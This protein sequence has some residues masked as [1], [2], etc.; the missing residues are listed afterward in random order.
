RLAP[1]SESEP[2]DSAGSAQILP[3]GSGAG[4]D[5]DLDISGSIS[6]GSDGDFFRINCVKGEFIGVACVARPLTPSMDPG[7]SVTDEVGTVILANDDG[8]DAES[9]F[10]NGAPWPKIGNVFDSALTFTFPANGIFHLKVQPAT[11]ASTGSYTLK[12]RKR[13]AFLRNLESP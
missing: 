5:N 11:P 13:S 1:V 9:I 12:I 2:N 10:P 3:L 6:A 7:C 4:Q 8:G